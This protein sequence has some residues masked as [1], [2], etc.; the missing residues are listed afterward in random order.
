MIGRVL[1]SGEC[2]YQQDSHSTTQKLYLPGGSPFSAFSLTIYSCRAEFRAK[3]AKVFLHATWT[4]LFPFR[5]SHSQFGEGM[6][7]W[8]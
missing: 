4:S 6:L 3:V 7:G 1:I 2:A 5:T 8:I